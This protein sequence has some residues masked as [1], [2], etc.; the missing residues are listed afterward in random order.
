MEQLADGVAKVQVRVAEI[1]Q[2]QNTY[3][4]T[5]VSTAASVR[6]LLLNLRMFSFGI[7]TLRQEFGDVNPVL[8]AFSSGLITIAAVGTSI[9]SGMSLIQ[10]TMGRLGPY[11]AGM[12]FSTIIGSAKILIGLLGGPAGVAA[13]LLAVIAIPVASW[14]M[15][16]AS[17]VNALKQE[18]KALEA[19]LKELEAQLENLRLEQDKFNLGSSAMQLRMRELKRALDL[20]GGSNEALEAQIAVSAAELE[21][22]AIEA[23]KARLEMDLLSVS[24]AQGKAQAADADK[25]ISDLRRTQRKDIGE[26]ISLDTIMARVRGIGQGL[27]TAVGREHGPDRLGAGIGGGSPQVTIN[28]PGATFNTEGDIEAA[29]ESGGE[30]AARIIYNQYTIPG[31]QR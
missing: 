2:I 21:N 17:G 18:I 22:M 8:E 16:S 3:R 19:D 14:A 4:S 28:F 23:G 25:Q 26:S 30:K 6:H 15:D 31:G 12:N 13:A 5:T 24:I 9:V 7:R 27:Q 1:N 20:A 10:G 11:L 29:L